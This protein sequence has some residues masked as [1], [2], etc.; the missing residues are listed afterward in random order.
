MI[1]LTS[2]KH[3]RYLVK[4]FLD[5]NF[6]Y[7]FSNFFL[8]LFF[9]ITFSIFKKF[10]QKFITVFLLQKNWDGSSVSVAGLNRRTVAMTA[11]L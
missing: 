11:S 9:I 1:N 10:T 2:T 6:H 7:V 3:H 5:Q 8:E 4:I